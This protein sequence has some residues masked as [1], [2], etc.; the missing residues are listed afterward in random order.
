M[1]TL[2]KI[3]KFK[4]KE[5]LTNNLG[6][7]LFFY[8]KGGGC[9]GFSYKFKV[10]TEDKKPSK[11]DETISLDEY[12]M[13]ICGK[14]ILHIIGTNID[15]KEDIMGQRFDFSN[16]KIESKCGCGTSVNFKI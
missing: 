10:L 6:K 5:L 3:A 2:T 16:D 7:A 15:Y 12:N 11:Y 8:I 9:N 1:I 13:Y 14:S 4:L